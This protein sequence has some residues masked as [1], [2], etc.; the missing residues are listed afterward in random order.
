MI[1][2]EKP[3]P[4]RI[5]EALKEDKKE[6]KLPGKSEEK[7]IGDVSQKSGGEYRLDFI[8]EKPFTGIMYVWQKE[9]G[10]SV[11]IGYYREKEGSKYGK[12]QDVELRFNED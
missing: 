2:I 8:E 12:K 7:R 6:I 9:K 5:R 3:K 1:T 10:S 4:G 11:W